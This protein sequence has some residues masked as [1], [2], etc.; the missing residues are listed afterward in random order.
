[1]CVSCVRV[2]VVR[3]VC[4]VCVVCLVCVVCVMCR[5][6]YLRHDKSTTVILAPDYKAES[7]IVS[8][9]GAI[10]RIF[11]QC[12]SFSSLHTR[13][14]VSCCVLSCVLGVC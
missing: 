13:L 6:S 4:V 11:P 10:L 14:V 9:V 1:V 7:N 3:V 8:L 12:M 5:V 2:R